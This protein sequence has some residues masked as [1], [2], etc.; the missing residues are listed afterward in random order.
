[1]LSPSTSSATWKTQSK[2]L[3]KLTQKRATH[4]GNKQCAYSPVAFNHPYM[5]FKAVIHGLRDRGVVGTYSRALPLQARYFQLKAKRLSGILS[6]NQA[7]N[8]A[9][10]SGNY[11][12]RRGPS[13]CKHKDLSSSPSI[14]IDSGVW[15]HAPKAQC[16]VHRNRSLAAVC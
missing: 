13:I 2:M 10:K 16:R 4:S 5:F 9:C 12:L 7:F 14:H 11:G 15:Q 6:D 8:S 3:Q 1:M